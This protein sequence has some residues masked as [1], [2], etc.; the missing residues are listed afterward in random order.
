MKNLTITRR[1]FLRAGT[2]AT[3][4]ALGY[5]TNTNILAQQLSIPLQEPSVKDSQHKPNVL[6]IVV[7]DLNNSLGCYGH[8][9]VKSPN[10]DRLAGRG[11]R[12]DSAY[13]QYTVCNPSRSS[14]LTG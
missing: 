8:S 5:H 7:D 4:A 11:I 1:Q 2:V 9:V 13:C 14:F 12:F 3:T 6:F 10:I